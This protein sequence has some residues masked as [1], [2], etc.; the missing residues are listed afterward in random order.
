[1]T[2]KNKQISRLQATIKDLRI[3]N[4]QLKFQL[5]DKSNGEG[6]AEMDKKDLEIKFAALFY[7]IANPFELARDCVKI[8]SEENKLIQSSISDEEIEKLAEKV[9]QA[10]KLYGIQR[11][12]INGFKACLKR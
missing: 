3:E 9:H 12:W 7:N 6:G 10:P 1:M 8:V 4:E 11:A 2:D 5:R